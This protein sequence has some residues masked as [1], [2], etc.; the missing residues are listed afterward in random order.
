MR[1]IIKIK[2]ILIVSIISLLSSCKMTEKLWETENSGFDIVAF[3]ADKDSD[4]IVFLGSKHP[5]TKGSINYSLKE[6]KKDNK[7]EDPKLIKAYEATKDIADGYRLYMASVATK[8]SK[9]WGESL[10]IHI[11]LNKDLDDKTTKK[12]ETL[13]LNYNKEYNL[14]FS[15]F[16]KGW[17]PEHKPDYPFKNIMT[18]YPSSK[19][20]FTN[21]CKDK[22]YYK[23]ILAQPMPDK[24]VSS[25]LNN[26]NCAKVIKLNKAWK[27]AVKNYNSN[28]QI[29]YKTA[30]TPFTIVADIILIPVDIVLMTLVGIGNLNSR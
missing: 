30:A 17:R 13:G 12:L 24:A 18:R 11:Y 29:A 1:R 5:V 6:P 27:G 3:F 23:Y 25:D 2:L 28:S 16:S 4:R 8:G 21:F 15:S 26:K 14:V 9:V 22:N 10:S 7:Y 20:K 19:E